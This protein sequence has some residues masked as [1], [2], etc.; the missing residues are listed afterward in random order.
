VA[1]LQ[2]AVGN[3]AGITCAIVGEAEVLV[4]TGVSDVLIANQVMGAEKLHRLAE[5]NRVADVKVCVDDAGQVEAAAAAARA[6]GT[7]VGVLAELDIG[8][9]RCGVADSG[10]LL[11]L[12]RT[13]ESTEGVVFRGLQGYEGHACFIADA[14]ERERVASAAAGKLTAA[15]RDLEEAGLN[16]EIVSAG[17]TGTHD[18]TGTF[19]GIDEL[20]VGSYALMDARYRTVRTD[21]DNA[22]FILSSVVSAHGD[23]AVFDV[24]YKS[25]GAEM[26]P[27]GVVGL[28]SPPAGFKLNEEHLRL[29]GVGGRFQV[30]QKVRMI[31]WHGCTTC[32]LYSE[33]HVVQGEEVRETWAIE[34]SGLRN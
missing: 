6:V 18:V 29:D 16:I 26:E 13:I 2:L 33:F 25:A 32:N 17:G 30:G 11:E 7:T 4:A 20:Q 5:L 31:P 34:A 24:G 23:R 27:P 22:L 12:A 21:F 8:M 15:R 28:D 14:A 3:C 9:R 1:R 10:E 19:E